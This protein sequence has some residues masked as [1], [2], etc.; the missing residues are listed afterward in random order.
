MRRL[1]YLKCWRD[2]PLVLTAHVNVMIL[3]LNLIL[4]TYNQARNHTVVG[5][6]TARHPT[7]LGFRPFRPNKSLPISLAIQSMWAFIYE[8]CPPVTISRSDWVV[9]TYK[10]MLGK[11]AHDLQEEIRKCVTMIVITL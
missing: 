7:F 9:T 1:G 6:E 2:D 10:C 4:S 3:L 8:I 5:R 11:E